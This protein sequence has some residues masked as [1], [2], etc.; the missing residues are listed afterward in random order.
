M[1]TDTPASEWRKGWRV[2][3]AGAA[4]FGTGP[5][6]FLITAGL[7]VNP[8]QTELGW[9]KS[10]LTLSAPIGL[11]MGLAAPAAGALTDRWG[12]RRV[13]ILGLSILTLAFFGFFVIPATYVAI[14]ALTLFIGI[15]ADMSG[16]PPVAKC[17]ADWFKKSPGAALGLAFNGSALVALVSVPTVSAAI[18]YFGWRSGFVAQGAFSL[19]LGLPI[20]VAWL[21]SPRSVLQTS[22]GTSSPLEGKTLREAMREWRFWAML[23]VIGLGATAAG[24]FLAQLQPMLADKSIGIAEATSLGVLYAVS[25]SIGKIGA[26]FLLDRLWGRGIGTGL[27]AIAGIGSLIITYT[28]AD[29]P[30]I[31]AALAVFCL[32]LGHGTTTV[33]TAYI[34]LRLFG[35][36]AY[37]TILGTTAMM[38]A[39]GSAVG[40]LGYARIFDVNHSYLVACLL[41]CGGF[42]AA[43]LLILL[44]AFGERRLPIAHP[45]AGF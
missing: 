24:G 33:L 36:R 4:C 26:G 29:T 15:V 45:R 18:H 37:S 39:I 20:V 5:S 21:R 13:A 41:G 9:S 40:G 28:T 38:A 8:M 1:S 32:A 2:V 17:V 42:L 27:F 25:L 16:T 10:A 12:G 14:Y 7:F 11:L 22:V 44:I 35:M 3:V 6:M 34:P 23:I 19:L 31:L 30:T 43:S